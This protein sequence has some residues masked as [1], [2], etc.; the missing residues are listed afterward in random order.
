MDCAS[1]LESSTFEYGRDP[2]AADTHRNKAR[3]ARRTVQFMDGLGADTDHC[4][5]G[6]PMKCPSRWD[7]PCWIKIKLSRHCARLRRK[8]FV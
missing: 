7:S 8:R 5:T 2:L 6:C 4:T 3:N 1:G